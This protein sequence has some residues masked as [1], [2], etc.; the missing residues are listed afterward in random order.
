MN[1]LNDIDK[2]LSNI[3]FS[4]HKNYNGIYLTEEQV[5]I[6]LEHGFAINKFRDTKELIIT[7]DTYLN[8]KHIPELETILLE[9]AE[10]DYY[11]NTN[12]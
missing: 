5:R 4:F 12:K 2:L 3:N 7:L 10:F 11:H 9:I 6:L 8:E 1:N